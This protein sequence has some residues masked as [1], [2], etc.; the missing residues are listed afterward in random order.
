MGFAWSVSSDWLVAMQRTP[1][2]L[3]AASCWLRCST[4]RPKRSIFQTS[5]QSKLRCAIHGCVTAKPWTA[6]TG[7]RPW[8][9]KRSAWV[10]SWQARRHQKGERIR[11]D[12]VQ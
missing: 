2:L 12:A 6:P 5:T 4:L 8:R 10:R 7:V 1:W 9:W 11:T 3:S